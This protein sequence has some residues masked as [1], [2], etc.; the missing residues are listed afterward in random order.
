MSPLSPEQAQRRR[1]I[2]GLIGL[3]A[4]GLDLVLAV[5]DRLGRVVSGPHDPEPLAAHP[6]DFPQP[7]LA[8]P[9]RG[10]SGP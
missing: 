3:M 8:A 7:S 5:G 10:R 6:P 9:P 1:R 4:P 2:E